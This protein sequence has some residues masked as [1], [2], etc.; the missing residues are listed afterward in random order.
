M[1]F[2]LDRLFG[3][4]VLKISGV[5]KRKA[6]TGSELIPALRFVNIKEFDESTSGDDQFSSWMDCPAVGSLRILTHQGLTKGDL[7]G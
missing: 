3:C 1:I 5:G 2:V 7:S 6:N 4:F